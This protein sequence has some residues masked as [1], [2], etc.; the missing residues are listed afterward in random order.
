MFFFI[1]YIIFFG[2]E[3]VFF[4][5]V[6]N[7]RFDFRRLGCE[8]F[9]CRGYGYSRIWRVGAGVRSCGLRF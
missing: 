6:V 7:G 5:V 1:W 3:T 2:S 8:G 9:A 4:K